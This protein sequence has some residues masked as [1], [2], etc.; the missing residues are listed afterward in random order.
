MTDFPNRMLSGYKNF[1]LGRYRDERDRYRQLAEAGQRPHTL[2]VA[3]CDSRAAPETI[4]DCGP[5]ELFVVRNIANVIPPY[6][7][8]DHYHA[9]SAALEYAIQVLQISNI[10]VMGHGRCGGIQAAL[11]KCRESIGREDF[12]GKWISLL[13]AGAEQ[14][15]G[16]LLMTEVERQTAL[17]RVSIRNSISNLRTF[18][19]VDEL[20]RNA[21]LCIYGA[22]FDIS[23][24]E[25]WVMN[26]K[27]DFQRPDGT[28]TLSDTQSVGVEHEGTIEDALNS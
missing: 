3:C 2:V 28:F 8:D 11:C 7:P 26:D 15:R 22:W 6:E 20:E 25:L 9:T 21:K 1:M 17:E 4:F 5:G 14:I 13:D 24:G 10:V 16:N 12:V 27:G 19:Y 18:P 23:T